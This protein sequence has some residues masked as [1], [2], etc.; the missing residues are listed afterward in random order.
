MAIL[1]KDM[2]MPKSCPCE[3]VGIGYDMYCAFV[4][5]IPAR[6]KEYD[7]CCEKGIRPDWCPAIEVREP[8]GRLIDADA[9]I[10]TIRPLCK[11][12][13]FA[14]CTFETVKRLMVEHINNA[15]TIIPASEEASA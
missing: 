5:G 8:H 15:P 1:I 14:V 12:D 10:S 4:H 9:F 7:E 3:L 13:K 11:E 2:E 6:V